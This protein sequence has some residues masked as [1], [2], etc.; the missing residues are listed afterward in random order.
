MELIKNL[1]WRYATKKFDA[2]KKID[3]DQ[4]L[5]LKRAIQLSA[6]SYGLQ[7]Y[8]VLFI[9]DQELKSR[10]LPVASNQS[11]IIDS[12]HLVVFCNYIDVI[13]RDIDEFMSL[14]AN[15]LKIEPETQDTF[16]KIL[17]TVMANLPAD[18]KT[19]WTSKQTYIAMANL[20]VACAELKIDACPMEGFDKVAF[21]EILGLR[22]K[23]LTSSVLTTIGYR[24]ED[25]LAQ[26]K[27][28]VRKPFD[29][30]FEDL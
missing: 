5:D 2:L 20:L 16:A 12:S 24:S 29:Q 10:L 4:I 17:K 6:S 23:G 22:A 9:S 25:D 26:N 1:E 8:K 7:A 13:D 21:D 11:Q 3:N 27:P 14:R 18:Q 19:A 15:T 28:K 30:L